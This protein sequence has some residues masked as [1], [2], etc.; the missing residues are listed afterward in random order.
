[1]V[2]SPVYSLKLTVCTFVLLAFDQVPSGEHERVVGFEDPL[3]H[4]MTWFTLKEGPL[5]FVPDI[6][7][8]FKLAPLGG[9]H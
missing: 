1:M 7:L 4:Q 9:H 3:T 2:I 5:F 6:N 8:Y